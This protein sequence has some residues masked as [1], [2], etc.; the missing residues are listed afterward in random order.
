MLTEFSKQCIT[1]RI[2]VIGSR[3]APYFGESEFHCVLADF[4]GVSGHRFK[5]LALFGMEATGFVK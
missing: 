4:A 3:S 1:R 5:M 2:G